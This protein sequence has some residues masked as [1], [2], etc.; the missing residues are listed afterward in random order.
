MK[1]NRDEA[2]PVM[3][4]VT[5]SDGGIK[6][7]APENLTEAESVIRDTDM[8]EEMAEQGVLQKANNRVARLPPSQSGDK[9]KE[10]EDIKNEQD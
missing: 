4:I 7:M 1:I 9:H 6:V 8:A 10:R 2:K 5:Y 3:V